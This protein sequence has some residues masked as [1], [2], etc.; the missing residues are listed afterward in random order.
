MSNARSRHK[1]ETRPSTADPLPNESAEARAREKIR[2]LWQ[3]GDLFHMFSRYARRSKTSKVDRLAG[4][5]RRGLVAPAQ[6]RDGTVFSDLRLVVTGCGMPYD[7]LVFLHRFGRQSYIYTI[8]EP[9]RFA[10]FVDPKIPVLTQQAM[11]EVYVRDQIPLEKLIGIAVHPADADSVLK[12][13]L[14]EFRCAELPLYDYDGNVL[15]PP[16]AGTEV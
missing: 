13:L 2:R 16:P 12:E 10:V 3:S 8:C 9:G 5:L 15:W 4:I 7:S 1:T 11:D 14:A 6:C